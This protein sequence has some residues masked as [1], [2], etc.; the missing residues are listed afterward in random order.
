MT[1]SSSRFA[2]AIVM[3]SGTLVASRM[4]EQRIPDHLVSPLA[5]I[6]L[7]ISDW[8]GSSTPRLSDDLEAELLATD[9]LI[10][11]YRRHNR[12]I[13]VLV[14]YYAQQRAGE[15]MHSP[16]NCLPGEGWEAWDY[17]TVSVAVGSRS[18]QV[19]LY[20]IQ[21]DGER[22]QVLYWYQSRSRIIANE[23]AA[24][25]YLVW[26]ALRNGHTGGALVRLIM[27]EALDAVDDEVRFA[28]LL[29]PE[30]QRCLGK[31]LR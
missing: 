13:N 22:M 11:F 9:Y 24:K 30:V 18:E 27:P 26:D 3:L 28:S 21:K 6:P 8:S 4:S 5:T 29:L 19:N 16:K 20:S 7:Q 12:E 15:S 25:V 10:R 1:K 17:R 2:A 23:Y 14:A 31:P